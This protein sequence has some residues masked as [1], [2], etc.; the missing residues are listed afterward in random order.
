M[1]SI[2]C[3]FWMPTAQEAGFAADIHRMQ[4]LGGKNVHY[5]SINPLLRMGMMAEFSSV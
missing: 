2:P 3:N 5:C 1:I 4:L